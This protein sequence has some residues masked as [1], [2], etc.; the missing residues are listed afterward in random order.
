MDI[1]RII[2][3]LGLN[4]VIEILPVILV[5][6]VT[7]CL[8]RRKKQKYIFGND[9]KEIRKKSRLNEI[10]RLLLLCWI[11]GTVCMTLTPTNFWYHFW[12]MLT[13]QS[14]SFPTVEFHSWR[15]VSIW[16]THFITYSGHY[17][18]GSSLYGQ[19]INVIENIIFFVP[20]G[21]GLPIVW[22][23]TNFLKTILI[24]FI[25]T[26]VVEFIQAFIGRDGNVDD[27]ICNTLGG[28]VG[29]LIYLVIK[30]IF[31]KFVERCK[32]SAVDLWKESLNDQKAK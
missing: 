13:F 22:K 27:M 16:W 30:A 10:V 26:F 15:Y 31:P 18:S 2:S 4:S 3:I 14:F 25:F 1:R 19:I 23:K 11:I 29:Y 17:L 8:I 9:F 5:T 28:I 7:Y 20:L 32:T 6:V 21:F 12:R 24:A